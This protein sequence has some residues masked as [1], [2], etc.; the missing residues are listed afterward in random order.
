MDATTADIKMELLTQL[1]EH[2]CGH[3][4]HHKTEPVL[5]YL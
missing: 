3:S 4:Y 2:S 1:H 5:I